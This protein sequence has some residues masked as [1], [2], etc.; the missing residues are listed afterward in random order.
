MNKEEIIENLW[1]EY[2]IYNIR[3][4]KKETRI[5]H[6]RE[7]L[8][9]ILGK[10][11]ITD[12]TKINSKALCLLC[13]DYDLYYNEYPEHEWE[14]LSLYRFF[15]CTIGAGI[16]SMQ[17]DAWEEELEVEWAYKEGQEESEAEEK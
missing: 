11:G 8:H 3:R 5:K 7:E 2:E 17:W 13:L 15:L 9:A 10:R 1:K 16:D 4:M 6:M 14:G 12:M